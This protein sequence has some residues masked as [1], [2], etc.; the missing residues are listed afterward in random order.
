MK[1][2]PF[3][4]HVPASTDEAASLLAEHEDAELLA[5]NQSLGIQ[6]SNRLATPAHLIDLNGIEDLGYIEETATGIEIGAMTRH[7]TIADSDLLGRAL[8][9]LATAAGEIAGPSVRN[10]GTLGGSL[11]EADPVGNYP[12]VLTA[13]DATVTVQS[14]E[15]TRDIPIGD[16]HVAYMT[17]ALAENEFV[18]SA[19]IPT[20][21]FP[22][23]RTGMAF[24]ELK[25]VPGTWPTLSAAAVLSYG[26][27]STSQVLEAR[28][29]IGNAADVPLRVPSAEEAVEG[30][31]L[32]EEALGEA[33]NAAMDAAR[34]ADEMHASAAY[35]TNQV[36]VF[37]RR[38]FRAARDDGLYSR[39]H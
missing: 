21:P 9:V 13:L 27:G 28:L 34:P 31:T 3:E 38:A 10:M 14:V 15:G 25:S 20:D 5:G 23:E 6:M 7:A 30:G 24:Q 37:T 39:Y 11:A 16:F 2:A 33:A 18:V 1:P 29:A 17:T 12:T 4:Y 32:T 26:D 8:P 36:G 22:E 19:T 35:K